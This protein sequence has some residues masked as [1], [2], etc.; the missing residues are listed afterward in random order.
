MQWYFHIPLWKAVLCKLLIAKSKINQLRR[1]W[2]SC[3]WFVNFAIIWCLEHEPNDPLHQFYLF[4]LFFLQYIHSS[5]PIFVNHGYWC[6]RRFGSPYVTQLRREMAYVDFQKLLLKEMQAMIHPAILT[7]DQPVSSWDL[8]EFV[9]LILVLCFWKLLRVQAIVREKFHCERILR[10][11]LMLTFVKGAA[12]QGRSV[13][14]RTGWRS[15]GEWAGVAFVCRSRG[16]SPQP[17]RSRWRRAVRSEA[18]Q[19][20][21]QMGPEREGKV[22]FYFL[23][24]RLADVKQSNTWY[25]DLRSNL[26]TADMNL[27]QAPLTCFASTNSSSVTRNHQKYEV[28]SS[29]THLQYKI[30][31][32]FSSLTASRNGTRRTH[33]SLRS[34]R[35]CK[36]FSRSLFT[37]KQ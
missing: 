30:L 8:A 3:N 23:N 4:S 24:C 20:H 1:R 15:L 37:G 16:A 10:I 13:H 2:F 25:R 19:N 18:Y 35:F 12:V 17:E 32:S 31:I 28:C 26:Q 11:L 14:W 7:T 29:G 33:D 36:P 6:E 22:S 5:V 27:W 21:S 34:W 9:R